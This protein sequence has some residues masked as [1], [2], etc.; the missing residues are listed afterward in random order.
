MKR[1]MCLAFG[2]VATLLAAV[3]CQYDDTNIWNEM[4]Q[5]KDRIETLEQAVIKTNEDIVALQTIVNALQK[6]VYVTSVEQS[7]EGYVIKFSDGT[8][9]TITN[10]KDGANGTN[11]PVISVK[12]DADGNYYWTIDGEWLMVDGKRVRANGI[13]GENGANGENGK[14]AIAPEVRINENSKEWEI[15]TDGGLTWTSTGVV[16]EGK[17]GANGIDGVNGSNGATGDSLFKSVDTSNPDYVIVT[18]ANGTT[19]RLARYDESSPMF[20]IDAPAVAEVE[21]GK[22]VEFMVE[23]ANVADYMINTP[24]GWRANYSENIL[25]VTAPTKE[26][27]HYDTEGVIAISVVSEAGKSAIVKLHVVAVESTQQPE[28]ELSYELRVLTFENSDAR[29]EPYTLDYA[30]VDITTWSDLVD[31]PQ[32]GGPLTYADFMSAMYTWYDEG[33]TELAHIFPDNYGYCY[34]GGG[35][36]IS[37]YWGEGFSDEDRNKHIAKYY[38]EDYVTENAGNDAMLG[39]FN[40]QLMTPVPA[41]SGDN[42]VVHYGYK[43]FYSYVEN[44]PELYFADG[45]ARVIDHMY[46]TNTS[47][48]LNQLYMGVKSEAGNSFGGN[49]E[50]L[51]E[52]AWLKIVAQGFDDVDADAYAEP[53]SEVEFYLVQGENVVTDWQKWDL[54]ELGS[55]AKVRFNFLYS[56]EMGGRY[57]FTIPGYFAYDDVAVR[58]DK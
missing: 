1:V 53:I 43:D 20:I 51:T 37:N 8:S 27:C 32:Y 12:Q 16:A 29:F 7:Y 34:W 56:E 19:F 44:L 31:N 10:G 58:F 4:E 13:D 22:S 48:T 23:V 46:I 38:G 54:S 2:V 6:S 3:G 30:G 45:E 26:L 40:L 55:V 42:F 35:H 14:D 36:A 21:W 57:G 41:H 11:A 18:L 33:N 24:E 15:S 50:G 47:Y 52:S 49:W 39:W 9:A 5:I 17:D 25:K 28:P